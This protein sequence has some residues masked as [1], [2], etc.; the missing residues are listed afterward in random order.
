MRV[1]SNP[2]F[3][4]ILLLLVYLF[5]PCPPKV[6]NILLFNLCEQKFV[7]HGPMTIAIDCNGLSSL[8]FEEK[9][10]NYA[11]AP[12]SASNNDSF[13]VRRLFNVCVWFFCAPNAKILLVYISAK[14]FI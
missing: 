8:I 11:S 7:Q 13:W 1:A 12:K 3:D 6:V 4:L 14:S 9:W 2:L 5:T 10:P